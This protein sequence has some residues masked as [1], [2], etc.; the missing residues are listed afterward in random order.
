[1]SEFHPGH[2]QDLLLHE[3]S[4]YLPDIGSES[5]GQPFRSDID[6]SLHPCTMADPLVDTLLTP[7]V[8]IF[9][10]RRFSDS[11]D[12]PDLP[13]ADCESIVVQ[14]LDKKKKLA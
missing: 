4:R 13:E 3:Y 11:E 7:A 12:R 9:L 6:I 10:D 5:I 1:M 8:I 14:V 2:T